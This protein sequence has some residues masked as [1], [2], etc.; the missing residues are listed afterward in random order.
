ML[1][2]SSKICIEKILLVCWFKKSTF[3]WIKSKKCQITS[4]LKKGLIN[5][6]FTHNLLEKRSSETSNRDPK[7]VLSIHFYFTFTNIKFCLLLFNRISL[8]S[9]I[10]SVSKTCFV[11]MFDWFDSCRVTRGR[12]NPILSPLLRE[13]EWAE[14]LPEF[15]ETSGDLRNV[16]ISFLWC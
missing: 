10:A 4:S 6:F 14:V 16:E 3:S 15:F 13:V 1:T 9:E 12:Y 8:V 7:N 2:Y 11:L 5:S